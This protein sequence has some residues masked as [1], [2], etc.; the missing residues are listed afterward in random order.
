MNIKV[1]TFNYDDYCFS[2]NTYIINDDANNCLI[3]DPGIDDINIIN[4]IN[5][6]NLSL[7][8][9]LLTHGHFDHIRGLKLLTSLYPTLKIYIHMYDGD[10]FKNHELN[11]STMDDNPFSIDINFIEV[12]E[13]S[14]INDL[15]EPI[16]IIHTPFHTMGSVCY[17]LENSKILFTGDTL[18][19]GSIGRFDLIN[20]DF[21]FIRPSLNKLYNL[22]LDVC[23]YPGHGPDTNIG[24]EK[25]FNVY[26]KM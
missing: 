2:C 5:C 21:H 24:E 15:N 14:S 10:C 12:D 7:K 11:A 25:K 23:V 26:F 1:E 8:G 18:F 22:S 19:K 9:V 13:N 20:S 6:H 17:Y 3:V 4:F 16:K